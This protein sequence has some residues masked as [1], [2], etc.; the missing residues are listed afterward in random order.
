MP[1]RQVAIKV[2]HVIPSVAKCR[3]GPSKAV[4]EMV[5][6]LGHAGLNAEIATTNDNGPE[7]QNVILNKLIDYKGVP[8]RFFNRLSPPINGVREFTYSR[9]F[10]QWLDDNIQNY[11][12]IHVHA[13][14]SFCSS[15][16]M[17]A[18]RR[19]STPYIVR[20]IGQLQEWSLMQSRAKKKLY[21]NIV[22]R[23]NLES[24]SA[25]QFTSAAEELESSKHLNLK[26]QVIPL[27]IDACTKSKT[28][29]ID[30][31][32]S[33]GIS[34]REPILLYLSRLHKKKGLELLMQALSQ[35]ESPK[36]N[37]LV[38]GDGEADYKQ[39]L[40][41][42]ATNLG[43][44]KNCFFLGHVDG[45]KKNALLQHSDFYALTSY[46]EN[47]G[48][49]VLE[50]MAN[51][52]TPIVSKEVA[53]SEIIS[54]QELGLVCTTEASDIEAQLRFALNNMKQMKSMGVKAQQFVSTQYSWVTI[55]KQLE[56]LYRTVIQATPQNKA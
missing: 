16:A 6:S 7:K 24:A 37:L 8:T 44:N 34:E 41:S 54:Q 51:G 53:L 21:L 9:D 38:A 27:G 20:P 17:Y 28:S 22:E 48:I 10:A 25:I 50:A 14:F 47:F 23:A 13:I 46:S 55:A 39:Q 30:L 12:L 4:I 2:L 15:Y 36:A 5:S 11:D 1:N 35:I 3:G 40:I 43:L 52:L 19:T 45:D 26:G 29:K 42:L 33:L 18:A 56:L 32:Q 31:A 49:S